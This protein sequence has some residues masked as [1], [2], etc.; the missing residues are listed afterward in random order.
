MNNWF[1]WN[2][3]KCTEYGIYVTEQPPYT[4]PEERVTFTNVPGRSGAL[5]TLEGEHVYEDTARVSFCF[6]YSASS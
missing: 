3:V 4:I 6:V 2:G 5:T 1:E